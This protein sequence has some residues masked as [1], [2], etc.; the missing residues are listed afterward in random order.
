MEA[1]RGVG[2][3]REDIDSAFEKAICK[4]MSYQLADEREDQE[5]LI[6]PGK[7]MQNG[8]GEYRVN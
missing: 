8:A 3:R 1:K 5:N 6:V 2:R 4:R 7:E